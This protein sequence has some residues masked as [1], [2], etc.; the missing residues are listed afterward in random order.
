MPTLKYW[1]VLYSDNKAMLAA[2][3]VTGHPYIECGPIV[4]STVIQ[5]QFGVGE[6]VTTN[7]GTNYTLDA[8]LDESDDC[9]FARPFLIARVSK[10]FIKKN[11]M[12]KFEQLEQLNSLIDKMLTGEKM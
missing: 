12:L 5:G 1:R 2:L 6:T 9:E 4:T 8:Q 10:D 7:S 3:E 11:K